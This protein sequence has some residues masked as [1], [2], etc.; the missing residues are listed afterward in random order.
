[1]DDRY[2]SD[3]RSVGYMV[4]VFRY[5][6]F[7]M[8]LKMNYNISVPEC[9]LVSPPTSIRSATSAKCPTT[10]PSVKASTK[11]TSLSVSAVVGVASSFT[12]YPSIPSSKFWF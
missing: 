3:R 8:V 12:V 11:T 9:Y 6:V 5:E 7:N 4:D 10:L 1:M 2:V